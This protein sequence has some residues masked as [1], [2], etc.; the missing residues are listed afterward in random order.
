MR[1]IVF[2]IFFYC[3]LGSLQAQEKYW[4]IFK[5]KPVENSTYTLSQL[6]QINRKKLQL[7]LLQTS[8]F[9]VNQ[10]Y[11]DTLRRA[12]ISINCTSRWLNAV[13]VFMDKDCIAEVKQLDFVKAIHPIDR[14]LHISSY[15][16]QT[17][18]PEY[19]STVMGQVNASAFTEQ[20]LTGTGVTIGV[21]DVGFYGVADNKSLQHLLS[22]NRITDIQDYVNPGNS[23]HFTQL[24]TNSDFHG[25]EVLQMITGF[26]PEKKLQYGMATGA[27]FCLART[28][29]GTKETRQEEDN[30]VMA[31][32]RMDSLG[33]RLINTSLGYALGFTNPK[34]NYRP[35]DM[36]GKTSTISQAT[37]IATEE[38]GML[39]VVSAG[40]EGDD[41]KWRIVSTP[42]DAEGVI[43]VGAT[44]AKSRDKIGYS[45]IGP[46]FLPYLKPNVSC[47]SPSGTSF[48]APVITGF[49][50]CLMQADAS[51]TNKQLKHVIEKSGHLYP[52][53]NNFVG[54]GVP[55]ASRALQLL[56]DSTL[57][58]NNIRVVKQKGNLLTLKLDNPGLERAVLFRKKNQYLVIEQKLVGLMKGQLELK[59]LPH[60]KQTTIDLGNEIVEVIWE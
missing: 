17:L 36:D 35:Q 10:A 51:L 23:D 46:D 21:I 60:E 7:P 8:D 38:K 34:E 15:I 4:V 30:W 45:S 57:S 53:G 12:G 48:S 41:P 59:R 42:A 58:L 16:P 31:M 56:K 6:N 29:H 25:T 37:M 40:N 47:F 33:I 19:Y 1:K 27:K 5:D 50:A 52:Y 22:D 18:T 14:N 24:E 11:V 44:K 55:D 54:Y 13:S 20:D 49:A 26:E 28:D 3:L 9:P 32:E 43:S 39:I 2:V